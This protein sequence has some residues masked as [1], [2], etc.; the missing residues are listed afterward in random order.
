MLKEKIKQHEISGVLKTYVETSRGFFSDMQ[1]LSEVLFPIK[2]AILAVE[3]ANSTLADVYVNLIK[4]AAVIQNLPADKY[5]GFCNHCIKKFN[6]R[7]EEFNDPVY[8]L[9]FFFILH[10]REWD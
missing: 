5:K 3:A 7:F 10:T 2:N 1:H 8:Q 9:A 4:I 6:H